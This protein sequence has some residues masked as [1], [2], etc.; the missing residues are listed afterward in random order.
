MLFSC[1]N[2]KLYIA[3][4]VFMLICAALDNI[5][6]VF[7]ASAVTVVIEAICYTTISGTSFLAFLKYINIMYGVRTGRLFSDYVNINM[8]GYPL[9]TGVLYGLFW[10][11]CIAVCILR[12]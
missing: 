1:E 6:F 3:W 11:V 5:I 10:L 7:V 2:N 8:F 12:L 9:N 4:L